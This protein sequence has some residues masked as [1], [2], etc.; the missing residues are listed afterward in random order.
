MQATNETADVR[1]SAKTLSGPEAAFQMLEQ[2][3]DE[4]H[5]LV[6]ALIAKITPVIDDRRPVSDPATAPAY[7]DGS[8]LVNAIHKACERN[9]Q[10]VERLRV[11]TESI[12]L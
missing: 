10:I 3:T 5:M 7:V 12:D 4:A 6:D 8:A 1:V 11:L 9:Q 2:I